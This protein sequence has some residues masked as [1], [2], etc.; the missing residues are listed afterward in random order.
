MFLYSDFE[1]EQLLPITSPRTLHMTQY[2]QIFAFFNLPIVA[3]KR[4]NSLVAP[5]KVSSAIHPSLIPHQNKPA[6]LYF[7]SCTTKETSAKFF[8]QTVGLQEGMREGE[9]LLTTVTTQY[10][11]SPSYSSYLLLYNSTIHLKS[12]WEIFFSTHIR[13]TCNF[14]SL[15]V[16]HGR[17]SSCIRQLTA[18]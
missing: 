1:Y 3:A 2:L 15:L 16:A 10:D 18:G 4:N 9:R 13:L 17:K 5:H 7:I 6:R 12:F 8:G 14:P 11:F